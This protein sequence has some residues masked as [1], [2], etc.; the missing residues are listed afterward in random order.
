MMDS[1]DVIKY[2]DVTYTGKIWNRPHSRGIDLCDNKDDGLG[3]PLTLEE[4]LEG[5]CM[6]EAILIFK[7]V[8]K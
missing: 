3:F 4:M 6:Y 7:K 8:S 5:N 2:A 1:R